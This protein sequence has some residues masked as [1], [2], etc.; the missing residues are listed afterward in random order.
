LIISKAI[1]TNDH[2]EGRCVRHEGDAES[3]RREATLEE[4]TQR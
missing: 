2:G 1:D 3:C 4:E